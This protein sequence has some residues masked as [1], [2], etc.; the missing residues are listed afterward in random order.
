V[1]SFRLAVAIGLLAVSTFLLAMGLALFVRLWR[2]RGLKDALAYIV[3][4]HGRRARF[5]VLLVV[6]TLA[7]VLAG[8]VGILGMMGTFPSRT[9]D[10][11]SA[12]TFLVGSVALALILWWGLRLSPTTEAERA[13]LD[14]QSS[15]LYALGVVDRSEWRR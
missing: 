9:T 1:D 13:V 8:I 11:L 5:A 6:T 14:G 15:R 10:A 12:L 3:Y 7:F 2:R 4:L